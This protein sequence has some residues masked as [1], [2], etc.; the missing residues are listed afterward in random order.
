MIAR[1]VPAVLQGMNK[2]ATAVQL[3]FDARNSP[4]LSE[5]IKDR[6]AQIAGS[7]M[8]ADGVLVIEAKAKRTQEQNRADALERLVNLLRAASHKPRPRRQTRPT[9]ASR[10]KRLEGK[11][12]RGETKQMRRPVLHSGDE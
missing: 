5:E 11:R 3:R 4:S 10:Q 6:L 8:T 1:S 9:L 7:R 12:E 2:V